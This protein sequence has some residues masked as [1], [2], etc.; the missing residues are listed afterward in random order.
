M[1]A[2]A[3]FVLEMATRLALRAA[4][5]RRGRR[6]GSELPA[7]AFAHGRVRMLVVLAVA[8]L[9]GAV[10]GH[11]LSTR[12]GVAGLSCQ[13]SAGC[14]ERGLCSSYIAWSWQAP[15]Y[16]FGCKAA[17]SAQCRASKRCRSDAECT[18]EQGRCAARNP[19]DCPAQ[20]CRERGACG[21]REGHCAATSNAHCEQ[22][23]RCQSHGECGLRDGAC[24]ATRDGCQRLQNCTEYG[25]CEPSAQGCVATAQSCK[26]SRVCRERGHCSLV[27][28]ECKSASDADCA[29][30]ELCLNLGRCRHGPKGCEARA[31]ADCRNSRACTTGGAC[32]AA[33]GSCSLV[34]RKC[35]DAVVSQRFDEGGAFEQVVRIQVDRR[36]DEDFAENWPQLNDC[37]ELAAA[38]CQKSVNCRRFG[39]CGFQYQNEHAGTCFPTES[40]HCE[41]SVLCQRDGKCSLGSLGCEHEEPLTDAGSPSNG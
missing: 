39:R 28:G 10:A 37:R 26:N 36:P 24:V 17:T 29:A 9:L 41:A 34:P 11:S 38:S 13:R 19:G 20:G 7:R 25:W 8:T 16:T 15:G 27:G 5:P 1:G 32:F 40:R 23:A 33:L 6:G 18:L 30:S 12:L 14:V 2:S 21:I 35:L 4:A 3:G 31:D 22:S